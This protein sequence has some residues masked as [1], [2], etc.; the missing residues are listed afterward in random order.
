MTPTGCAATQQ[1]AGW[2]AIGRSP[3]LPLR[4]AKWAAF[5]ANWLS[6]PENL[7]ALA[8]LS[9][10]WIDKVHHR[11]PPKTIVLDV[12]SS[13]SPTYGA[14]EGSAYNAISA[15]PAI[16]RG[17]CSTSS[18][19]SSGVFCDPAT[20]TAPMAGGRCWSR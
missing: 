3:G 20:F 1:W 15:A 2:W 13:E 8:D 19:M 14:Q 11:R 17:S 18:A 4:R 6:R 12:D 9:G 16:T 10:Q 7:A 5:Q